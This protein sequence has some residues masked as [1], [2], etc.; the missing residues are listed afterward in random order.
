MTRRPVP[1]P[2]EDL[3]PFARAL[4]RELPDP[5]GHQALLN[6]L[7]RAG[8]FRNHKHLAARMGAAAPEP[9]VDA[10]AL[11]CAVARFDAAGRLTAWPARHGQAMLC[12]WPLWARL[13]GGAE[14]DERDVSARLHAGMA[15]RD[16]ARARRE[17]VGQEMLAR[18][19]DGAVY[20][21]LERRPEPTAR[22]L[23]AEI[24]ARARAAA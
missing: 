7:A 6:A 9:P 22:A 11:R 12:L 3:T 21:R 23:I 1:L 4:A 13:P 16:A 20:R 8:G 19:D 24:G 15:F 17:M 2:I 10:A 18:T 5:P 14:M